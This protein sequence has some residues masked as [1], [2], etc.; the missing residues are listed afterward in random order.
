MRRGDERRSNHLVQGYFVCQFL[1]EKLCFNYWTSIS[2]FL[3]SMRNG[4]GARNRDRSIWIEMEFEI[5]W[6]ECH[7]YSCVICAWRRM[8]AENRIFNETRI[9]FKVTTFRLRWHRRAHFDCG[10]FEKLI[11][12]NDCHRNGRWFGHRRFIAIFFPPSIQLYSVGC[13]NSSQSTNSNSD[14]DV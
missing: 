10:G 14:W 11:Y 7:A 12:A 4:L 9:S 13:V 3:P 8:N 6:I 5:W 2:L 1:V